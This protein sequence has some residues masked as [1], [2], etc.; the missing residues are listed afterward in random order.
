MLKTKQ[1]SNC[2]LHE[3]LASFLK[4]DGVNFGKDRSVSRQLSYR[5]DRVAI[6]RCRFIFL[7]IDWFRFF[8][9]YLHFYLRKRSRYKNDTKLKTSIIPCTIS[10]VNYIFYQSSTPP[11]QLRILYIQIIIKFKRP[12]QIIFFLFKKFDIL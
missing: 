11:R 2:F 4:Q 10:A 1:I 7:R 8:N 9:C 6:V 5:I 12:Y 3:C